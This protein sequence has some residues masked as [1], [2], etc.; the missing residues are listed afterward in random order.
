MLLP[1]EIGM[2]RQAR[3]EDASR[4]AEIHVC[5]WRYEYRGIFSD[6]ELFS[7]RQVSTAITKMEKAISGNAKILIYEDE[8]DKI[9]KGFAWHG[10]SRDEDEKDAYELYAIYV[11]PEFTRHNVGSQLLNAVEKHAEEQQKKTLSV[12]VLAENTNGINFYKKN[13]FKFDGSSKTI[14]E[15]SK[16]ENRMTKTL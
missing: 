15:W 9:V 16:I 6:Y 12:W 8:E 2:I 5:G 7:Q 4:I 11:Q 1:R 14:K 10:N 13:G 3:I